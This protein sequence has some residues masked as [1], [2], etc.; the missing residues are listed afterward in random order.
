MN[1]IDYL[2]DTN[3]I[4]YLAQGK[5]NTSDFARNESNLCISSITYI[6]ALGY[7][8]PSQDKENAMIALFN[9]KASFF[10]RRG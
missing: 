1:G 5:L 8:F 7:P 10:N 3:I 4:I 6:E 2:L 9:V